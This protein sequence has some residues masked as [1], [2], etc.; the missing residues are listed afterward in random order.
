MPDSGVMFIFLS[1]GGK[2]QY[3]NEFGSTLCLL[4]ALFVHIFF[5]SVSEYISPKQ[6]LKSRSKSLNA[7]C[8]HS[9]AKTFTT[10]FKAL[11]I[12]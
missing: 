12:N 10:T 9:K 8:I 2:I 6:N 11:L 1:S 7:P 3:K 4:L 5:M